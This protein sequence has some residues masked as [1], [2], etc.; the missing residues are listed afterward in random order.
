M[1]IAVAGAMLVARRIEARSIY[2]IRLHLRQPHGESHWELSKP[3]RIPAFD[4]KISREFASVVAATGYAT[5]VQHFWLR[6][7]QP[8]VY[9]LDHQGKLLG[10][11][12]ME[13]LEI[14]KLGAIP[15]EAAKAADLV[16]P[17]PM[18]DTEMSE[19]EVTERVAVASNREL[20]VIDISSGRMIGVV[21]NENLVDDSSRV[22][23]V[24]SR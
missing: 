20:P 18:L 21:V 16:M 11:I 10:T 2:T 17:V 9:V 4:H 6:L 12:N 13:L 22:E 14:G 5:V 1:L 24:S 8:P 3:A 15:I 19:R 23:S 7:L